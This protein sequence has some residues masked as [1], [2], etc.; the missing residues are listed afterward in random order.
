LFEFKT[1]NAA[2]HSHPVDEPDGESAIELVEVEIDEVWTDPELGRRWMVV[3][4]HEVAVLVG[5]EFLHCGV[6]ACSIAP[7]NRS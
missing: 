2:Q 6:D 1:P 5:R 3:D 4:P 7:R